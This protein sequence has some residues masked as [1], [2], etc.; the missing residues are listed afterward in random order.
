MFAESLRETFAASH[1]FFQQRV[2]L[3]FIVQDDLMNPWLMIS[4]SLQWYN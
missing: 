4:L 3:I 1:N 2:H